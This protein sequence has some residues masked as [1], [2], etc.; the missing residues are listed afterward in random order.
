MKCQSLF[1]EI[2]KINTIIL[3]ST[4]FAHRM[5]KFKTTN[6]STVNFYPAVQDNPYL[7]KQCR[8]RSEMGVA[9]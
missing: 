6:N 9:N 1:F 5:V 7:Y 3:S 8:S 4:E 2:N